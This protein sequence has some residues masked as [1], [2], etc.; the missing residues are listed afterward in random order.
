MR[1]AVIN[2][3]GADEVSVLIWSAE[4][5]PRFANVK[6]SGVAL[7]SIGFDAPQTGDR[8]ECIAGEPRASTLAGKALHQHFAL[9]LQLRAAQRH[10]CIG[11]AEVA[12]VLRDFVFEDEMVAEG[13]P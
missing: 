1:V 12:V 2:R 8:L 11:N 13:I 3:S 6:G 7:R 5:K 9:T 10:E 4:R